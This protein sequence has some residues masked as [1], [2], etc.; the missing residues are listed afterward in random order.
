[1]PRYFAFLRAINVGGHTLTMQT[2]RKL[3]ESFGLSNVETFI[4]SGN[5]TFQ[6]TEEDIPALEQ[7]IA[8]GLQLALGYEVTTFIRS[9][10][11]LAEIAACQPFPQRELDLAVAY[12]V[13]F[14][15]NPVDEP[16]RQ[17]LMGLTSAIDSFAP[18]A[19]EVYWLC[20]KK[21]SESSFSN[22]VLEKNLGVRSTLRGMRT[23]RKLVARYDL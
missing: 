1:M 12:N 6:A 4:A 17:K 5:L 21:Q 18:H 22:A 15:S 23:I 13:A 8:S 3:C 2:L 9:E 11:E 14:L 10:A 7:K 16:A 19:R 20:L